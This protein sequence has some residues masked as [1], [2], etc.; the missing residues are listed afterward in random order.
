M[1]IFSRSPRNVKR[2]KVILA[3]YPSSQDSILDKPT[4]LS[5]DQLMFNALMKMSARRKFRAAVHAV[6]F[7]NLLEDRIATRRRRLRKL[8]ASVRCINFVQLLEERQ[9][10]RRK[11]RASVDTV[12]LVNSI[13]RGIQARR[14]LRAAVDIITLSD[15]LVDR[16]LHKPFDLTV[17]QD[18]VNLIL[19][20]KRLETPFTSSSLR[21]EHQDMIRKNGMEPLNEAVEKV[22]NGEAGREDMV[23]AAWSPTVLRGN[24]VHKSK[25]FT[26]LWKFV[27]QDPTPANAE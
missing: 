20:T 22:V 4:P 23:K 2:N 18:C 14:K 13:A 1:G 19:A 26:T 12:E 15:R 25:D 27:E 16:P 11:F 5:K 21:E 10:A 24:L 9:T 7:L 3:A 6:Q 8:R 17:F